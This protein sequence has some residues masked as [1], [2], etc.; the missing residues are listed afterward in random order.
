MD[1]ADLDCDQLRAGPISLHRSNMAGS[2]SLLLLLLRY[3]AEKSIFTIDRAF[4]IL[5]IIELLIMSRQGFAVPLTRD[6]R[7][8]GCLWV[9]YLFICL[10]SIWGH[11]FLDKL[12]SYRLIFDGMVMPALLGLYAIRLFPVIPNLS[13][14]SCVRSVS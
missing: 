6:V 9:A 1:L 13:K 8:A 4:I 5:L 11:P 7:V 2:L 12:T 14:D 10:V 3:P